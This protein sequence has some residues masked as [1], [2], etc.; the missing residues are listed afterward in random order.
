MNLFDWSQEFEKNRL[1][2]FLLRLALG[3]TIAAIVIYK[4][5]LNNIRNAFASADFS[6]TPLI[7]ALTLIITLFYPLTLTVLYLPIKTKEIGIKKFYK[8]RLLTQILGNITPNKIGELYLFWDLKRKYGISIAPITNIYL[9]DKITSIISASVFGS[10]GFFYLFGDFSKPLIIILF[11]ATLL[12]GIIALIY[13][14]KKFDNI[15]FYIFKINF[16]KFFRNVLKSFKDYTKHGKYLILNLVLTV[17]ALFITALLGNV[18][19]FSFGVDIPF[20]T[21][22]FIMNII[23]IISIIPFNVV[24]FGIK[25][26]SSIYL[27]TLVG[28]DANISASAIIVLLIIRYAVY[29]S[30]HL[31][32]KTKKTPRLS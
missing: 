7:F 17:F 8:L 30:L 1:L 24:G 9:L 23:A 22:F 3:I 27:F 10:L 15:N 4:I 19:F 29:V 28:I 16:G 26:V 31:I 12:I 2:K 25:E 18:V 5:G 6:F 21:Y 20:I 11:A 13:A 14:S 32:L